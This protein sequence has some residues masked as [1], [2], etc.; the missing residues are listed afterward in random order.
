MKQHS[1]GKGRAPVPGSWVSPPWLRFG[2]GVVLAVI[3][4]FFVW[5]FSADPA[6][7]APTKWAAGGRR[8]VM[9]ERGALPVMPRRPAP[10]LAFVLA[11]RQDLGLTQRQVASLSAIRHRWQRETAALREELDRAATRFGQSMDAQVSAGREKGDV[12]PG[13]PESA[14]DLS[15][16]SHQVAASRGAVWEEAAQRLTPFQRQ[17]AEALWHERMSGRLRPDGAKGGGS[18]RPDRPEDTPL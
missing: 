4:S 13:V 10:D 11:H 16:F 8:P 2:P 5:R 12:R 6:A 15:S 9:P 17:Q 14:G 7:Q 1:A 18:N 3:A